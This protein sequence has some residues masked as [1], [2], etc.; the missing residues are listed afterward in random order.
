M[1]AILSAV[2]LYFSVSAIAQGQFSFVEKIDDKKLELHYNGKLI[3]AYYYGDSVEKPVLFPINTIDGVTIT[4]G[5]PMV[6]RSG[7]RTD[8]PHHVG[9]WLNYESVNGL[10]FWNNSF[11]IPKE[12]K[13]L[14]GSIEHQRII[15]KNTKGASAFLA[16]LSHWVDPESNVLLEEVTEFRFS[17]EGNAVVIDR[18][19]KL[20]AKKDVTFK[21]VKDG[22]LGLRV[23]RELEMPSKQADQFVDAQGNVTQLPMINNEGVSGMYVNKEGVK[24][25]ETWGKRSVWT[26]LNG[27]KDGSDI[28]IVIIDHPANVGYPTYWHA[29]GYGLFAANPLGQSIFSNGKESL[30]YKLSAGKKSEFKYRII[31]YSGTHLTDQQ[32][33]KFS[34]KF[35]R[36]K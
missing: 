30:N 14:Y 24:G 25:D 32:I 36:I 3:T 4:R 6:S 8:H 33:E 27:K 15:S 9:L 5:W 34:Q 26:A 20:T 19:S 31:I 13:Y 7:E 10:D 17:V 21:D 18:T 28:S 12:K 11:A 29:R 35:S 22:M 2:F 1:R 23:A 16:T